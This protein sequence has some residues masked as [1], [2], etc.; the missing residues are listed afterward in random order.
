[1][2]FHNNSAKK[3]TSQETKLVFGPPPEGLDRPTSGVPSFP[4]LVAKERH[5]PKGPVT[6]FP[7]GGP[8]TCLLPPL[9]RA[10]QRPHWFILPPR[11][12][13]EGR[14]RRP[15]FA[16]RPEMLCAMAAL[17]FVTPA[18]LALRISRLH[19]ASF[20]PNGIFFTKWKLYKLLSSLKGW[21]WLALDD[22]AIWMNEPKNYDFGGTMHACKTLGT[23]IFYLFIFSDNKWK[24]I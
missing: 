16:S 8:L 13:K 2:T 1:M 12:A 7:H 22:D 24:K 3:T 23:L 11:L 4:R 15:N 6:H 14:E 19:F 5:P 17:L 20:G 10:Q 9:F 18:A 21:K